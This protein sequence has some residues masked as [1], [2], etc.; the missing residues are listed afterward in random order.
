MLGELTWWVLY[1]AAWQELS[2]VVLRYL[3]PMEGMARVDRTY[4]GLPAVARALVLY[5]SPLCLALG[6][7]V[8]LVRVV[9]G[10]RR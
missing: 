5:T 1:L 3:M 4:R 10:G 2:V 9:V 6:V 8:H 7:V